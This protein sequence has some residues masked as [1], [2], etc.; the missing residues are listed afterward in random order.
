MFL[1]IGCQGVPIMNP[2]L[3]MVVV[4]RLMFLQVPKEL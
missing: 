1:L 2:T 4:Q 3:L